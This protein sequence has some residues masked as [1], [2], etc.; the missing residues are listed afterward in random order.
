LAALHEARALGYRVSV[1]QASPYGIHI[2]R[3][4]GF[5]EYCMMSTYAWS[6]Q[7]AP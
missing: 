4:L 7:G 6:P 5:R 3:R 2:Y 1:L